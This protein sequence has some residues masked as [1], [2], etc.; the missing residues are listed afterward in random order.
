MFEQVLDGTLMEMSESAETRYRYIIWFPYTRQAINSIQ[1]GTMVAIPNFASMENRTHYSVLEIVSFLPMHYA[2]QGGM[3]GYPGFVVEAARSAT[4]DWVTQE[5]ESTE[6]TTKI[7]VVAMPTNLEI[8][9]DFEKD[10]R[11]TKTTHGHHFRFEVYARPQ[12]HDSSR[13]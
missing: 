1:E 10:P 7:Q 8:V 11:K 13:L 12:H 4:E 5:T 6:D 9:E 3:D 2:L